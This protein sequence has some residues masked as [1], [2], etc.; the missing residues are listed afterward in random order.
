MFGPNG[1]GQN[2][3]NPNPG[4][5]NGDGQVV[6][7][8]AMRSLLVRSY[9]EMCIGLLVTAVTAFVSAYTGLLYD[10]LGATGMVGWIVL[11]IAQIAFA[12]V[13]SYRL[14]KMNPATARVLFY[15]YAVLM[16]FTLGS[17]FYVFNIGTIFVALLFSAGFFFCLTMLAVSTKKNLLKLGPVLWAGLI[18]FVIGEV[19]LYF[20]HASA[21]T[22]FIS[23]VGL[24][25]F[26][27]LTLY[28]V[29]WIKKVLEP[30]CHT[31]VQYKQ[32]SIFA[33]LNLY[34][35]FINIFLSLLQLF[36]GRGGAR[37]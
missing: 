13:L 27:G 32:A 30:M 24:V 35:D 33:A 25:L 1:Q 10:F 8:R 16:G 18:V 7:E 20:V 12:M 21:A 36:G 2:Y 4:F 31:E 29:Q 3:T 6:R 26:G 11:C 37:R 19:I 9:G 34:L 22:M 23:A 14:W 5:Y 28:E 17:I 15:A